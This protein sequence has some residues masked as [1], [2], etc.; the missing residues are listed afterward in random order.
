AAGL[1]LEVAEKRP[2]SELATVGI[3]LF[4]RGSD[5]VRGA[6][7]MI[8]RNDRVNN[9]FYTAPVYN[10]LIAQ[11]LRIGVYEIAASAMHGLGTPEGLDAYLARRSMSAK[12]ARS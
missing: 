12:G 2:I 6:V 11:G 5:F 7:D 10:Y 3:Y 8:A 9:E 4:R 1:V